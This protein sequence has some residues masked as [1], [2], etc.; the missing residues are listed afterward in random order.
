MLAC[1]VRIERRAQGAPRRVPRMRIVCFSDTHGLH[2]AVD[3]PAGDLLVH[4]GDSTRRG[5]PE[6]VAAFG[7][8]LAAQPHPHKVVIAGNHDFLFEREPDRARE[9]LGD[10]IYLQDSSAEVEGLTLWGS[11]WQPRYFDWAFN[12]SRGPALSDRWA[13]VPQG[14]DVLVTHGPPHG[15]LDR[16]WLLRHVGCEELERA[17]PRIRPGLH[18]FGHIHEA[19][20]TW[21]GGADVGGGLFVNASSCD[22]RYRPIQP[23]VVVEW[24]GQHFRAVT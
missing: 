22:R 13:L 9:L 11:P 18:V 14:V 20:G 17:L 10:V 24:D 2:D 8:F 21:S 1:G 4:A 5:L 7:E 19:Y 3:L 12:L 15:I 16:T 23:P 6:E